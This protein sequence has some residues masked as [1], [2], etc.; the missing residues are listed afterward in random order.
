M[1]IFL[2]DFNKLKLLRKEFANAL[3]PKQKQIN[4]SIYNPFLERC[5]KNN[6]RKYTVNVYQLM[7]KNLRQNASTIT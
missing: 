7:K 2:P 5:S 6:T 4:R 1:L 3:T